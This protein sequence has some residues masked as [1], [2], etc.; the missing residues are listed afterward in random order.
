MRLAL[1]HPAASFST[2]LVLAAGRLQDSSSGSSSGSSS[3]SSSSSSIQVAAASLMQNP[4]FQKLTLLVLH[5]QLTAAGVDLSGMQL[6]EEVS[7]AGNQRE[8]QQ[9]QQGQ[10]PQ[11]TLR[12]IQ[13]EL[14]HLLSL[15]VNEYH[16]QLSDCMF[17]TLPAARTVQEC[18]QSAPCWQQHS[19]AADMQLVLLVL[20]QLLQAHESTA[21]AAAGAQIQ[22]LPVMLLQLAAFAWQ[23]QEL[24]LCREALRATAAAAQCLGVLQN[25]HY[26]SGSARTVLLQWLQLAQLMLPERRSSGSSSTL[27]PASESASSSDAAAAAAAAATSSVAAASDGSETEVAALLVSVLESVGSQYHD[28]VA[29][30]AFFRETTPDSAFGAGLTAELAAALERI[31]RRQERPGM[32]AAAAAVA[33]GGS[34]TEFLR[35]FASCLGS[36][37]FAPPDRIESAMQNW[38]CNA[39]GGF[40]EAAVW[41]ADGCVPPVQQQ[42][43]GLFTSMLKL[44]DAAAAAAAQQR[45]RLSATVDVEECVHLCL[46]A[47]QQAAFYVF[48]QCQA[49]TEETSVKQCIEPLA[50]P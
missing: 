42:L 21:I 44:A 17:G 2:Q 47:V 45:A 4:E 43:L 24:A 14:A 33:A 10:P 1:L 32:A 27:S 49:D 18:W 3:S 29:D 31:V 30:E 19:S 26:K 23:Q 13:E 20:V 50:V 15:E 35:R 39:L 11:Q 6:Q 16:R 38:R 7:T 25:S 22:H 46:T 41:T 12:S 28:W 37:C 34:T 40:T 5:A 9:G 36:L 48:F 8:Q